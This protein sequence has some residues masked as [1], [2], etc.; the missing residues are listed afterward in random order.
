[1][2]S[3]MRFQT[4]LEDVDVEVVEV[5]DLWINSVTTAVHT[6]ATHVHAVPL[7]S[8]WHFSVALGSASL[9]GFAVTWDSLC[10]R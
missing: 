4:R 2:D 1:M 7:G 5:R 6:A 8:S 9:S 10:F 3:W